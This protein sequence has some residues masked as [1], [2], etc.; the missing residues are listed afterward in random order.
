MRNQLYQLLA[1]VMLLLT[2]TS[3]QEDFDKRYHLTDN[4][5]EFED[6][7]TTTVA[8]G[9][10]YPLL[11]KTVTAALEPV[12]LQ[13]NMTGTQFSSDQELRW[14]I[15]QEESTAV[16]GRDYD[17]IDNQTVTL[18]ANSSRTQVRIQPL[19]TG[20]SGTIL[21][22]ELVGNDHIKPME[23]YKRVGIQWT[24]Q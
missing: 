10:D 23:N 19:A 15:V 11:R 1:V 2:G 4:F 7:V 20:E 9:K 13:V 12:A 14:Q 3:C 24:F 21:V 6:A 8:V 22:L 18:A 16:Q 17:L 5:I